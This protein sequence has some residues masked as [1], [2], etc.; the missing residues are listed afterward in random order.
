MLER[1]DVLHKRLARL[2]MLFELMPEDRM[3]IILDV[4]ETGLELK[5]IE[6]RIKFN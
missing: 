3:R 6:N 1:I 2:T 5:R 4:F